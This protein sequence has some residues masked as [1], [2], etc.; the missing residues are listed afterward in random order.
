M[1]STIALLGSFVFFG[2]LIADRKYLQDNRAA[3][4]YYGGAFFAVLSALGIF[5]LSYM[6]ATR[7]VIQEL[8]L[9]STYFY[10]HFQYN[11]FFLFSCIG[12][13]VDTFQRKGYVIRKNQNRWI[14]LMMFAG[15]FLGFGLSVLWAQLPL[16]IYALV[17]LGTFLQ[18]MG[19]AQIVLLAKENWSRI[20]ENQLSVQKTALLIV[21]IAFIVK[22]VLQMVSVIPSVSQFAFGFRTIVIAYLHLILLMC[23]SI[24]LLNEILNT[25]KFRLTKTVST[26][27]FVLMAGIL[28]NELVLGLMGFF[29]IT[30]TSIPHSA[31]ILL[32]ISLVMMVS[33]LVFFLRLRPNRVNNQ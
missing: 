7:H 18:T 22:I 16:W 25:Q 26:A 20:I 14:F 5:C 23:I 31:E 19:A 12:L 30:Y 33:L 13:L 32:A 1:F 2:F 29:S 15:G 27:M 17:V 10:L 24:F 11:G 9:G 6:M 4:W 8:Y 3:L 28:C 21:G